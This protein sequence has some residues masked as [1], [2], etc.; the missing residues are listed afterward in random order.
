M[1]SAAAVSAPPVP[2]QLVFTTV[3]CPEEVEQLLAIQAANAPESLTPEER[4]SQGYDTY[5]A[6]S[7]GIAQPCELHLSS[8]Q[9]VACIIW[10][11]ARWAPA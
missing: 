1:G 8:G 2:D 11:C 4:A 10:T 6:V 5:F 3:S 9:L 7:Q